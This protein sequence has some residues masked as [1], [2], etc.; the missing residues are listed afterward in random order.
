MHLVSFFSSVLPAYRH[1]LTLCLFFFNLKKCLE[2]FPYW[3]IQ[4]IPHSFLTV[5]NQSVLWIYY[6]N[7]LVLCTN[8][9]LP[10]ID[11]RLFPTLCYKM[12]P[13]ISLHIYYL[14]HLQDLAGK[15][16]Q[17][18]TCQLKKICS[19]LILRDISKHLYD[20]HTNIH[21]HQQCMRMLISLHS[22]QHNMPPSVF[23]Y[24]NLTGEKLNLILLICISANE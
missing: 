17:N 24:A 13:R 5:A 12:L 6:N 18:L 7:K 16:F 2:I 9:V 8:T 11:I 19:I 20:D 1:C 21:L 22:C 4:G 14:T 10:W 23:T 3:Y 15:K